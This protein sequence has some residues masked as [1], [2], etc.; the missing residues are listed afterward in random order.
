MT[1]NPVNKTMNQLPRGGVAAGVS[2]RLAAAGLAMAIAGGVAGIAGVTPAAL[3]QAPDPLMQY[4][5]ASRLDSGP[6]GL[7]GP[8]G[9]AEEVIYS[10][11]LSAPGAGWARV[12][13]DPQATV[14]PDTMRLRITSLKDGHDQHLNAATIRQWK[15]KS[16]YLNGDTILV[17]VLARPGEGVGRV[18]IEGLIAGSGLT[19]SA[20]GDSICGPTDDRQ[21]SSD[22]RNAR[23]LPVGC[24]AWLIDD[25]AKCFLTAGHCTFS[26]DVVEFNVPLSTSSGSIVFAAPE[27][28]YPVDDDSMQSN[29]GLGIGNDWAYFGTHPNSDTGLTAGQAQGEFYRLAFEAPSSAGDIRITGYGSTFGTGAPL[30]WSQVQKTHVGPFVRRDGYGISYQTDTTGGN[31]GSPVIEEATGLAIGIHTHAGCSTTAGNNGT[32]IDRPELQDALANPRGVCCPPIRGI[33]ISVPDLDLITPAVPYSFEVTIVEVDGPLDPGSA[34]LYYAVDGADFQ[35][36]PLVALGGDRFQATFPAIDCGQVVRYY[37]RATSDGRETIEPYGAPATAYDALAASAVVTS[38]SLDFQSAPGWSTD[39]STVQDGGWELGEPDGF[40]AAPPGDA[41][42]SGNAFVTGADRGQDLDGGPAVLTSPIID[43]SGAPANSVL[44]YAR[45]FYND[46][47]RSGV[48]DQDR[49]VVE[50]SDDAGATWHQLEVVDH[51]AGG[52]RWTTVQWP[53]AD[54]ISLTNRVQLRF[55][56]SDSPNDSVTEA[57]IDALS[58]VGLECGSCRRRT[59]TATGS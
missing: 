54:V 41:D 21:L 20:V 19:S 3:A 16:A 18:V 5:V 56:V 24:T 46:D 15:H 59:S 47:Q 2:A 35:S 43:L 11:T 8:A 48:P 42:G 51:A 12:R 7:P 4:D 28:Q 38:L 33:E 31:S 55:T 39:G 30:S 25:C 26:A 32:A 49:L 36:V 34:E 14:L 58:I 13:F 37:V 6:L 17:E 52:E 57:A 1:N 40:R 44:S 50:I 23:L 29:G 45:W 10:A 9:G 22:P 27:D 53:L